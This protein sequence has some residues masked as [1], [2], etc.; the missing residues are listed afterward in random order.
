MRSQ[1]YNE[2]NKMADLGKQ[3]TRVVTIAYTL[4][5][6]CSVSFNCST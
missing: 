1:D 4:L 5:K 2:D 6:I 3:N